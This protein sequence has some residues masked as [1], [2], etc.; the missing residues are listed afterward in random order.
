MPQRERSRRCRRVRRVRR[1]REWARGAAR[2]RVTAAADGGEAARRWPT[3]RGI[4]YDPISGTFC[5]RDFN[6]ARCIRDALVWELTVGPGGPPRPP[7]LSRGLELE[8]PKPFTLRLP[9][10]SQPPHASG[11]ERADTGPPPRAAVAPSPSL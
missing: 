7:Y 10:R 8:T 11:P 4:K 9:A 5:D 3:Q 2:R 6:A 1:R